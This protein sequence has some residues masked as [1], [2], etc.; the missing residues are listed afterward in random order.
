MR[1]M[2]VFTQGV[3]FKVIR[4][5]KYIDVLYDIPVSTYTRQFALKCC[6]RHGDKNLVT[7]S[8]FKKLACSELKNVTTYC[9]Y[10]THQM[11]RK[12][13]EGP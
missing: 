1:K 10:T 12:T 8:T 6:H 3:L 9:R 13:R 4:W 2:L 5:G 7:Q 11:P